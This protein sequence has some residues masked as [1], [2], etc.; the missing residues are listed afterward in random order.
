M[1][2]GS[3]DEK[4]TNVSPPLWRWI[5]CTIFFLFK[6]F[7]LFLGHYFQYATSEWWKYFRLKMLMMGFFNGCGRVRR[8]F[9][10]SNF[11]FAKQIALIDFFHSVFLFFLFSCIFESMCVCISSSIIESYQ[12]KQNFFFAKDG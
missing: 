1:L 8:N 11:L 2:L 3:V 7:W 5:D 4:S 6:S 10:S 9:N 12:Q